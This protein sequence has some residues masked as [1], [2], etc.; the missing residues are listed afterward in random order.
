M[1]SRRFRDRSVHFGNLLDVGLNENSQVVTT[2][3][4]GQSIH[5]LVKEIWRKNRKQGNIK[6][7]F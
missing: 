4:D 7:P 3:I 6:S 1:D 5:L 2:Y